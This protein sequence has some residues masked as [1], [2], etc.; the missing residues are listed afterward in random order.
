MTQ[1][2]TTQRPFGATI[3]AIL[4]GIAAVFAGI[5]LLQALGIIPYFIGPASFRDFNLWNAIMWGLMVWVYVW[6]VQMLWQVRPEAWLFLAV[7]TVFNLILGFTSMIGVSTWSDV[8]LSIILNAII[9]V[10]IMLPGVRDS[11]GMA[12]Q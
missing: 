10:Y 2:T 1:S 5:H 4:A 3:L 11:F 9:L 12:K 6:L 8:S 7:I